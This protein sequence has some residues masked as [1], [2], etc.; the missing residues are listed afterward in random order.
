MEKNLDNHVEK[1]YSMFQ[2][3]MNLFI[4]CIASGL[5]LATIYYFTN[6]IAEEKAKIIEENTMKSLVEDAD[7]FAEVSGK[8]GWF[9]A[10][11]NNETI[12]YIVPMETE[13]FSGIIRMLVAVST[14][15]T[16]LKYSI[17]SHAETPGLGDK[18]DKEPFKSQFVGKTKEHLVVKKDPSKTED[19]V[20][21]TGATISSKA[22]TKGVLEAV[23]EVEALGGG[24]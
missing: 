13:G 1:E 18:A 3:A 2:I 9:A 11:K 6:P 19:I 14:D 20:A 5:L 16:V 7:E 8:E 10:S 12:A 21:L 17:L 23:E 22:I 24:N 15:G 4:T